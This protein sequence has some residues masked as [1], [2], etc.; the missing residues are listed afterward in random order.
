MAASEFDKHQRIKRLKNEV[1]H[2]DNEYKFERGFDPDWDEDEY[3]SSKYKGVDEEK[4]LKARKE[5][6]KQK[7]LSYDNYLT[8]EERDDEI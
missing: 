2:L 1:N 8:P 5:E 4:Y 3:L 6:L 7:N